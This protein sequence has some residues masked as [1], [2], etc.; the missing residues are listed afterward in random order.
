M[1]AADVAQAQ[2]SLASAMAQV[3]NSELIV[4]AQSAFTTAMQTTAGLAGVLMA[5]AG[6]VAWRV[7]PSDNDRSRTASA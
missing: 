7:I 1:D 6:V 2:R 4:H 3:G 5:V